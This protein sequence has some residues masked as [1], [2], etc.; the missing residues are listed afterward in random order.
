MSN[1]VS[2]LDPQPEYLLIDG[3]MKLKNLP[4]SQESIIRGDGRSLSIAAASIL[5]KV[6]RDR[7]M[8][9]M[10]K[11]YPGYGFAR[12]KGYCTPQHV[13]ALSEIGPCPIHRYS[14]AP[15]R[16]PLL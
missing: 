13:A 6:R 16:Q 14:F 1:A 3:R 10:D 7:F 15:I 4:I 8:I 2:S 9:K 12:H 11:R 5:A